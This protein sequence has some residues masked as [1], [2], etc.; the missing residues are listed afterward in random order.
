MADR[1]SI[2]NGALQILGQG[3][4]ATL[5]ENRKSR[6]ALDTAWEQNLVRYCLEQ[7]QWRFAVRTVQ[8]S[9][10]P[11]IEPDFGLRYAFDRPSDLVR[12]AALCSDEYFREPLW[13]ALSEGEFFYADLETIYLR[14]VSDDDAYGMNMSRWPEGFAQYVQGLLAEQTCMEITADASLLDRI[15]RDNKKQNRAAVGTDAMEEPSK[16]IPSGSWS[17]ARFNGGIS[18]ERGSRTRLIG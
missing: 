2:Y 18:S 1:L 17:R 4:L 6:R 3:K 11:S 15:K 7:A 16:S 13:E 9:Y 8:L 14:Y 10:S 12:L 5:T